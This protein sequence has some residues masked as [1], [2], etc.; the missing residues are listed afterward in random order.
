MIVVNAFSQLKDGSFSIIRVHHD[1]NDDN[2][3]NDDGFSPSHGGHDIDQDYQ[4]INTCIPFKNNHRFEDDE[5]EEQV[6]PQYR[7][8]EIII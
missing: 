6:P 2:D 4:N 7:C 8:N 3:D 1:D 5:N